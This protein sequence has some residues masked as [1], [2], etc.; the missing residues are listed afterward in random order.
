MPVQ[1]SAEQ[2]KCVNKPV[3]PKPKETYAESAFH[4]EIKASEAATGWPYRPILQ[5]NNPA[6]LNLTPRYFLLKGNARTEL[7]YLSIIYSPNEVTPDNAKTQDILN[8]GGF[9]SL[10]W[11]YPK[12][13]EPFR[14]PESYKHI[15][16]RQHP[17]FLEERRPDFGQ[18]HERWQ[19]GANRTDRIIEWQKTVATGTVFWEISAHPDCYTEQEQ[20]NLINAMIE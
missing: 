18:P 8:H 13:D 7:G 20:I 17:A 10:A 2:G 1:V 19:I 3:P 15:E 5:L 11:F 6:A 9:H 4:K 14:D 16:V 12:G